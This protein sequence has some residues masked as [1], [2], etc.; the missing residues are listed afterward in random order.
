MKENDPF[1]LMA[2]KRDVT[3]SRVRREFSEYTGGLLLTVCIVLTALYPLVALQLVN[4]FSPDFFVNTAYTGI[5]SYLVYLLF[6]PEGKRAEEKK[7]RLY[8]TANERLFRLSSP[9]RTGY[10]SHF[11]AFCRERAE[12]ERDERVRRYLIRRGA[13]DEE[14]RA[15]LGK[16]RLRRILRRAEHIRLSPIEP[17]RI[18]CAEGDTPLSDVGRR[19]L[20]YGTRAML[21]RPPV[22]LAGTILLS[23][24]AVYPSDMTGLCVIVKILSAVFG[25][26]MAAFSGYAAGCGEIRYQG[27]LAERK[28]LFLA[29]F[30]EE[31]GLPIPSEEPGKDRSASEN[32]DNN[33][34]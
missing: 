6:F 28:C 14:S 3:V 4:P 23:S 25:V 12:K 17:A 31:S 32:P 18:L 8:L 24:V 16:Y 26:M 2:E 13:A 33:N 30:Y 1:L 11:A 20:S 34:E 22:L 9:I 21:A 7:N 5:S 27:G 29:A 10:F 15:V 19:K